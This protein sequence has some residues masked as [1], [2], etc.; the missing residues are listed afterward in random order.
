MKKFWLLFALLIGPLLLYLMVSTGKN[1]F[2]YLPILQQN[3]VDIKTLEPKQ[4]IQ[5]KDKITIL[6][7]FGEDLLIHKTNALN[8]NEKIYKRNLE[9]VDFQ[10]VIVLPNGS[11]ENTEVLKKELA[12]TTDIRNW[13]FVFTS[14]E[15]LQLLFNSLQ[16]NLVLDEKLYS[17]KAFIIDKDGYLRGRNK[18]ED[19][20]NGLLYGYNTEVV[21]EIHQKMIDDVKIL[22]AEYRLALKKNKK[23]SVFKNPYKN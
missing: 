2:R 3:V 14:K 21:S 15:S 13:K 9:F 18:D 20:P 4:N 12:F 6:C 7:F 23:K 17:S 11:E 8:L 19:I 22:L 5:F 1:K 10:F 16:T